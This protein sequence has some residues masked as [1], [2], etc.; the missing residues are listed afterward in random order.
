[1]F[2]ILRHML[3]FEVEDYGF[4]RN[5]NM[6]VATLSQKSRQFSKVLLKMLLQVCQKT[7]SVTQ[8]TQMYSDGDMRI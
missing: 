5:L 2:M 6:S 1:M 4:L 8:D 7:L 3:L